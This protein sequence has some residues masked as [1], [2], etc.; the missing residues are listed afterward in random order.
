MKVIWS[1][2]AC[3][4]YCFAEFIEEE[5]AFENFREQQFATIARRH[6]DNEYSSSR[7]FRNNLSRLV[8][9]FIQKKLFKFVLFQSEEVTYAELTLPRGK[10]Y[11]PMIK[12]QENTLYAKIDHS[13]S[14]FSGLLSPSGPGGPR[15]NSCFSGPITNESEEI[16]SQTPLVGKAQYVIYSP[17]RRGDKGPEPS[18][19]ESKV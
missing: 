16:T 12:N 11:T 3:L 9:K 10:G 17:I 8:C 13:R 18:S 4:T 7:G 2:R 14:M 6:K 15:T 5:E 19:R 1:N